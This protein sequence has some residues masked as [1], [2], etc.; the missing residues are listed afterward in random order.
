ML[1]NLAAST[2]EQLRVAET[3]AIAA[4][5]RAM[6]LH[7]D[8]RRG[9]NRRNRRTEPPGGDRGLRRFVESHVVNQPT[10]G[11]LENW[12]SPIFVYLTSDQ[13]PEFRFGRWA[14]FGSI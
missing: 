7:G 6:E 9:R 12:G 1:A 11:V 5:V 14:L 3:D 13:V 4:A 10:V 8:E 2:E